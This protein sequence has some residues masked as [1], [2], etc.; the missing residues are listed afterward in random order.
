VQAIRLSKEGCGG[1][2]FNLNTHFAPSPA[3]TKAKARDP[4]VSKEI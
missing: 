2:P 1:S 4:H 3:E